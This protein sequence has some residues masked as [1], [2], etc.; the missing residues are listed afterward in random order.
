MI[1]TW[2]AVS[3]VAAA[4]APAARY[5]IIVASNTT[6]EGLPTLQYADDDALAYQQHF[7]PFAQS[8]DLLTSLD[9][10]TQRRQPAGA[11]KTRLPTRRELFDTLDRRFAEIEKLKRAGQPTELTFVFVGH[12]G[13]DEEG[14]GFLHLSDGRLTRA[15]LFSHVL[16]DSPADFTHLIVDACHAMSLVAGRGS[17]ASATRQKAFANFLSSQELE[18]YPSVGVLVATSDTNQT[19]EWS[20]IEAGVFSHLVRSALTGAADVNGD[21]RVEYS[22]AAAFVDSASADLRRFGQ[23][24]KVFAWPP[25]RDRHA[26]LADFSQGKDLRYVVV[27]DSIG[28]RLTLDTENGE[29]WAEMNKA[30]GAQVLL[31]LPRQKGFFLRQNGREEWIAEADDTRWIDSAPARPYTVA[32][33]GPSERALERG[34]FSS[35]FGAEY[36]RGFVSAREQLLPVIDSTPLVTRPQPLQFSVR[37]EGGYSAGLFLFRPDFVEHAVFAH[38]L[39]WPTERWFLSLTPEVGYTALRGTQSGNALR[40]SALLGGGPRLPL[41]QRVALR[42]ALEAG[43][44]GVGFWGG[45]VTSQDPFVPTAQVR[46]GIDFAAFGQLGLS[47]DL[48]LAGH[49]VTVAGKEEPRLSPHLALAAVW[50]Q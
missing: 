13:L 14:H 10:A 29:H 5:V 17:D 46:L 33:R 12:G 50:M 26:P 39:L 44:A 3:L 36:Y 19:Q 7:A 35:A 16:K 34:L 8:I 6:A 41:T 31:A 4:P 32:S 22:E 24:L 37:L 45:S 20:R 47:L 38:V 15:E 11:Q 1:A 49:L 21:G 27:G 30:P 9:D 40:L 2:L 43:I 25:A 42:G 23:S 18:A 28:G 48:S